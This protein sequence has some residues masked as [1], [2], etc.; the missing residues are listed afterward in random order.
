[1]S[2]Y[3]ADQ[4]SA[5]RQLHQE[6][7]ARPHGQLSIRELLSMQAHNL[8]K[9]H[10]SA[11]PAVIFHLACWCPGLIGRPAAEIFDHSLTEDESRHSMAREYGF[12]GWEQVQGNVDQRFESAVDALMHGELDVLKTMIDADTTLVT[13]KSA[14]GHQATLLHYLGANGV[15]TQRQ[16]S[17]YNAEALCRLLVSAGADVNSIAGI[18]GGSTALQLLESSAHPRDA[19]VVEA[20][21]AV[22][23]ASGAKG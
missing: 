7:L 14:Y 22:L 17:P 16:V 5:V 13:Q 9:G 10:A 1:M 15:E 2:Y 11:D 20:V 4:I 21:A 6:V 18:Y 3:I 8:L 23:R 19:G 12:A